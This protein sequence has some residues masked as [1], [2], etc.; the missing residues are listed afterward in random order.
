ME[1]CAALR[2]SPPP[3]SESRLGNR[4]KT[5]NGGFK[6]G[7]AAEALPNK[8]TVHHSHADEMIPIEIARASAALLANGELVEY[9]AEEHSSE[10]LLRD[11]V[12]AIGTT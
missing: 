8:I 11:A 12:I 3:Q 10:Q 5:R 7:F 1:K 2:C 4:A 9:K 6:W